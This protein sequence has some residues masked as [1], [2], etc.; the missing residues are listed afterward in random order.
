MIIQKKIN[1]QEVADR[2]EAARLLQE[3]SQQEASNETLQQL[4]QDILNQI[5]LPVE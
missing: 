5:P 3:G 1:F 2:V 4:A